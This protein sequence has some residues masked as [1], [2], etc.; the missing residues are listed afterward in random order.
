MQEAVFPQELSEIM[1]LV[2]RG[3]AVQEQGAA[4]MP[5]TCWRLYLPRGMA[6][7]VAW[8]QATDIF[9]AQQHAQELLFHGSAAMLELAVAENDATLAAPGK[10]VR[11][12]WLCTRDQALVLRTGLALEPYCVLETM[13]APRST[14]ACISCN[15]WK[16]RLR[17]AGIC[18][19]SSGYGTKR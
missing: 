13:A 14:A 6:L 7:P 18:C 3:C 2:G 9:S 5:E 19:Q 8:G 1:L 10:P 16:R 15:P 4:L 11:S 12:S 17:A